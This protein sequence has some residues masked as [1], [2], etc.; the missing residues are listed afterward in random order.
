MRKKAFF[1]AGSILL[2]LTGCAPA[3]QANHLEEE[4]QAKVVQVFTVRQQAEQ[5]VHK[6]LGIVEARGDLLLSFGS[7][8]KIGNVQVS[9]GDKVKQGQLLATL[10]TG[11]LQSSIDV[12]QSEVEAASARRSKVLKGAA[13]EE[14]QKQR[15]QVQSDLLRQQQ[16]QQDMENGKRLF[17]G[18]AISQKELELLEAQAQQAA[19]TLKSSQLQL[20]QLVNGTKAEDV[21]VAAAAVKQAQGRVEQVRQ[22]I[23]ETRIV[24]PVSGTIVDVS[25][26]TGELVGPGEVVFHL[27]DTDQ[28][29]VEIQV[30]EDQLQSYQAGA[31][32]QVSND[33]GL[34]SEGTI[35]FVSPARDRVTG[36]YAVEIAV[37]NPQE[38]WRHGMIATVEKPQK[39][40]GFIVP[41][42]SVG[43]SGSERF[44][45]V[46]EDGVIARKVV[47][48]GRI[49]GNQMEI[50][51][52]VKEGDQLLR[53]GITYYV[54]GEKVIA[55]ED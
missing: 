41:L 9:K 54:A 35:A 55:K 37:P 7:A 24:A 12:A 30:D 22:T 52:G 46:V 45:M 18:G 21:T 25:K 15:L 16:V 4:P 23:D 26:R 14:I 47:E 51:S 13:E 34:K 50:L 1:L 6:T 2:I 48:T 43:I 38:A 27:M 31:S 32:V 5:P 49:I 40:S 17:A 33:Q 11:Y 42:E 29:V 3:Q 28:V 19:L 8:G 36:K 44:V 20:E 10:E 53:T 39:L